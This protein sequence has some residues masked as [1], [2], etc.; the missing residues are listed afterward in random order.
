MAKNTD[1]LFTTK[2]QPFFF[3]QTPKNGNENV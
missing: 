1:T 3:P 2:S